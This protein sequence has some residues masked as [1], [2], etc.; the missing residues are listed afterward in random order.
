NKLKSHD[1]DLVLVPDLYLAL[2]L[3]QSKQRVAEKLE[4][5]QQQAEPEIG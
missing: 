4:P 1:D 2:K 3:I 5:E